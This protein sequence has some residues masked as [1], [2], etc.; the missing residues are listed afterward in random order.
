MCM[1][2]CA[3]MTVACNWTAKFGTLSP[4]FQWDMYDLGQNH[5]ENW[6]ATELLEYIF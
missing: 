3:G 6:Q 4:V 1:V 5:G 2:L